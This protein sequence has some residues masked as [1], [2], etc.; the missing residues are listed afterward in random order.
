MW[1]TQNLPTLLSRGVGL[2]LRAKTRGDDRV[3]NRK[4]QTHQ[5]TALVRGDR[6]ELSLERL[7]R[8]LKGLSGALQ[9]AIL[10]E[11]NIVDIAASPRGR[12][13]PATADSHDDADPTAHH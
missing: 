2:H 1:P 3:S 7:W 6:R 11:H 9:A 12:C 10:L 8:E 5:V 13:T 4:P